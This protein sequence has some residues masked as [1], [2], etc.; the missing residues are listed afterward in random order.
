MDIKIQPKEINLL[1]TD[2][3]FKG[4]GTANGDMA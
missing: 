3:I 1:L 4:A 2:E